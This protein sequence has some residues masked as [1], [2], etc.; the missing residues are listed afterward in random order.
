MS[1][2]DFEQWFADL[3]PWPF[4]GSTPMHDLA[5]ESS[6]ALVGSV[7]SGQSARGASPIGEAETTRLSTPPAPRNPVEQPTTAFRQNAEADSNA[8]LQGVKPPP[9]AQVTS[10]ASHSP[11]AASTSISPSA[12][13]DEFLTSQAERWREDNRQKREDAVVQRKWHRRRGTLIAAGAGI[14]VLA[15]IATVLGI[16]LSGSNETESSTAQPSSVAPTEN[17][18]VA[19]KCPA[20]V[21]GA[22]TTGADAGDQSSGPNVIK[23]FNYAYYVERSAENAKSVTTP[24]AVAAVDVMQKFIN[25]R[26][27]GTTHCLSITDRGNNIYGVTLTETPPSGGAPIVYQ[28]TIS[29]VQAGGKYW[30]ASIKSEN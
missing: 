2:S 22:V 16:A 11:G 25:Q 13:L 24:N 3:P 14:V 23:A 27:A 4:P 21:N 7:A 12:E 10:S 29:T 18:A 20:G 15:V 19:P 17:S 5:R 28:Q 26:G 30:I 9:T 1:E 8:G 6:I